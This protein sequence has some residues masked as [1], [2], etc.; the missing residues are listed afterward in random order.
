MQTPPD[1]IWITLD[2]VRADRVSAYGHDHETTPTFDEFADRATLFT[3]VVAQAPWS[4]PSH[5]SLFTGQYPAE[6]GATTTSPVLQADRTLPALLSDAGYE[7]YA[8]SPNEY[9]RP[10]TG[11]GHGFD[12]FETLSGVSEPPVVADLLGPL[13][14]W[15]AGDPT[16]RRPFEWAL[17]AVR[18]HDGRTAET[19]APTDDG[20]VEQFES[21]LDQATS[22]F[23]LFVNLFDTH[24]PRSPAPRYR[25]QFVDD[26]L[27]DVSVVTNER[28]HTFGDHEMGSRATRKMRQLY[29]AD[30]R[31][32][33]DRLD[34]LLTAL[35]EAGAVEDALVALFAD[36]GEH[37]GEFGLFGHQHSVFDSAVSVPLAVQFPGGAP[38]R[39]TEQVELRRLFQTTLDETGV[40][41]HP[42]QSLRSG[43]DDTARGSFQPPGIDIPGVYWD[44]EVRYDPALLGEPITFERN[45]E[46]KR[47][48]FAGEEWL[49][50]VPEAGS[51]SLAAQSLPAE[52]DW[53]T[54]Q[55]DVV[56]E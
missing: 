7:T 8:I 54:E 4:I 16:V 26:D 31:T 45:G 19:P 34:S 17:T 30:L 18:S 6:H 15:G 39:V 13:L 48:E 46:T 49:F 2:T 12:E 3:D 14:D 37:L 44:G 24:L 40:A 1:V 21:F 41:S 52:Y 25:Q 28:A 22:P 47:I 43:G 27:A 35:S 10:A 32:M 50:E 5:G 33:D 23:F 29:D 9:V 55:A 36:H 20:L 51:E 11:F 56:V 38:D 53:L 42:D